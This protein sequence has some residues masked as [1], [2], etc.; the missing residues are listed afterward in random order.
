[1]ASPVED[2]AVFSAAFVSLGFELRDSHTDQG[3]REPTYCSTDSC[4]CKGGDNRP[5]G[6]EWPQSRYRERADTE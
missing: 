6:N 5:G 3:T 4:P 1:M 2:T